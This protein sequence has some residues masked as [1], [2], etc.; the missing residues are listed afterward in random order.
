MEDNKL[1]Y[2][3]AVKLLPKGPR[4]HSYREAGLGILLGADYERK[5]L[6]DAMKQYPLYRS[7]EV[8]SSMKHGLALKD[9]QGWLFIETKTQR[10]TKE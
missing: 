4:V 8:A 9:E 6:L 5:D 1:S 7:G 3:E 2:E 10:S